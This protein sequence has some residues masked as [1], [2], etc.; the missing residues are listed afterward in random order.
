M[1]VEPITESNGTKTTER[2]VEGQSQVGV[3]SG[4]SV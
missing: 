1:C 3:S 4:K 2:L